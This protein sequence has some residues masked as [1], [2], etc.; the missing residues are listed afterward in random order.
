LFFELALII[1]IFSLILGGCH[2]RKRKKIWSRSL[3]SKALAHGLYL[4]Q[5]FALLGRV[6]SCKALGKFFNANGKY[7]KYE[8]I[9]NNIGILGSL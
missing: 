5:F 4:A 6:H 1:F 9:A 2:G 8:N 3:P 7:L